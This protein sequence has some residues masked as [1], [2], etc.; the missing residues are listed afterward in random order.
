MRRPTT[1]VLTVVGVVLMII[2]YFGSAPW[3]TSEVADADPAF[4]G[5]PLL[6]VLGIISI[7]AA[8]VLYEVLPDRRK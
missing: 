8:V 6:F 7:V 1:L 5:A 4:V 3:G 2:G